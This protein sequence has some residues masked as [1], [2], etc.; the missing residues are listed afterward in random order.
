M[1]HRAQIDQPV[2]SLHI[3]VLLVEHEDALQKCPGDILSEACPQSCA[4][5]PV[6][7]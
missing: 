7:R 4:V 5:Q 3:S 2:V 1:Q 6:L